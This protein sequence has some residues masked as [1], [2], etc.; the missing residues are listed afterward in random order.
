MKRNIVLYIAVSLDGY[1]ARESG[2]VDWL[3]GYE[4]ISEN[5]NGY[6]KFYET[7]D[8]VIMGK[9]TYNQVV[10]ELSKDIWVYKGKKCYVATSDKY[11]KDEN[12][13]FILS[14]IVEFT[15]NLK[16]KKGKDIWLVGGA[17]L[18]DDFI[19]NNLIDKYIISIIPRILGS[20]ISLFLDKN[21]EIKLKLIG[22]KVFNGIVAVSYTHLTLPTILLV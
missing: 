13:E 6:E 21:P 22:E 17:K 19:K 10:N 15:K 8:T 11:S 14:D 5:D 12:V 4:E 9:T 20:G 16:H 2:D 18:V 7:I 3:V 1:I